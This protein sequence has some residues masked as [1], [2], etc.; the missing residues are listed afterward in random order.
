MSTINV[1]NLKH[2]SS[3]TNSIVFASDGTCTAKVANISGNKNLVINGAMSVSQRGT[4]SDSSTYQVCDRFLQFGA[5]WDNALTVSQHALTSSD[6]GPWAKGFR[7]SF[8]L[9]NGNQSSGAGAAD[10]VQIMYKMEA[11]DVASSGW[12]YTSSS[13][14]ITL[15]FWVQS[16]VAQTYYGFLKTT[17]GTA[18]SYPFSFALSANTWTKVTKTIPGHANLQFDNDANEGLKLEWVPFYGTDYT[19]SGVSLDEWGAFSS[20]AVMADNTSTWYTTDD[21][22]FELTGV[23]LEVGDVATDFEFTRY[24]DELARCQRYY[25]RHSDGAVYNNTA[26]GIASYQTSSTAMVYLEFPVTMRARTSMTVWSGS[27]GYQIYVNDGSDVL[28]GSTFSLLRDGLNTA[29]IWITSADGDAKA[30]GLLANRSSSSLIEF[31]AEL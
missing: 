25:Y 12:D 15:S 26:I 11:Q 29:Q 16:S 28:T 27:N 6:T 23:Q 10:Y 21:A 17:D 2:G 14:Y 30:A 7:H 3:S 24:G 20:S 9:Q 13:S 5:G 1:T 22:T 18:Q 8:H 4:T 31:S 19:A